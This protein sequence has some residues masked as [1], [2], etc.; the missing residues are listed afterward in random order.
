M[1]LLV[2]LIV[3]RS[4]FYESF[5]TCR[6]LPY[7]RANNPDATG[8]AWIPLRIRN[9][10][11]IDTLNY[12]LIVYSLIHILMHFTPLHDKH[13]AHEHD[14]D[15][16]DDAFF[17]WNDAPNW[18]LISVHHTKNFPVLTRIRLRRSKSQFLTLVGIIIL[19][20]PV[21][22]LLSITV[23][24]SLKEFTGDRECSTKA[25]GVSGHAFLT[26]WALFWCWF[27]HTLTTAHHAFTEHD[28]S[29]RQR[30]S[31]L[32]TA[33]P[34]RK[35]LAR[36]VPLRRRKPVVEL[37]NTSILRSG[38]I[39]QGDTHIDYQ[40]TVLLHEAQTDATSQL[41]QNQTPQRYPAVQALGRR[42]LNSLVRF[43]SILHTTVCPFLF[44]L[45][46]PMVAFQLLI[47]LIYGYHSIQQIVLGGLVALPVALTSILFVNSWLKARSK[48]ELIWAIHMR[49]FEQQY[50]LHAADV[51][52]KGA[53]SP[54]LVS[55]RATSTEGRVVN[56]LP[57]SLRLMGIC[58]GDLLF[59]ALSVEFQGKLTR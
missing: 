22:Y 7:H 19:A 16:D 24:R 37:L 52:Y 3:G 32:A 35:C 12:I 47:T 9:L 29:S 42:L 11:T 10:V 20:F 54:K 48:A 21:T 57:E 56:L 6:H 34:L 50:I 23:V 31:A 38:A 59:N 2:L 36:R 15:H 44:P 55:C 4:L 25:N 27:L 58:H 43:C 5:A 28:K 49:P 45:F 30:L 8:T 26:T 14:V 1:S 41:S 40:Y 53:F 46:F 51:E 18:V 13:D 17:S 39:K 33:G